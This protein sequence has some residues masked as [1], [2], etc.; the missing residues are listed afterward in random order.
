MAE[1]IVDHLTLKP[2]AFC[3]FI[4]CLSIQY[5]PLSI[6]YKE[7]GEVIFLSG[8]IYELSLDMTVLVAE[9]TLEAFQ[10]QGIVFEQRPKGRRGLEWSCLYLYK[11]KLPSHSFWCP[12][13]VTPLCSIPGSPLTERKVSTPSSCVSFAT[14]DEPSPVYT[15]VVENTDSPIW[16]FQQQSRFVLY[17]VPLAF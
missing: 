6:K 13:I 11:G 2:R 7:M 14:A 9:G 1:L 4:F 3:G 10:I 12:K 17:D 5:F 8:N 16:N 15:P